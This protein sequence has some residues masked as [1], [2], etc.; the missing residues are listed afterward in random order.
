MKYFHFDNRSKANKRIPSFV[1]KSSPFIWKIKGLT[2][3]GSRHSSKLQPMFKPRF[4]LFKFSF[5]ASSIGQYVWVLKFKMLFMCQF[6]LVVSYKEFL[7]SSNHLCHLDT[8][9]LSE[10]GESKFQEFTAQYYIS[11]ENLR[12]QTIIKSLRHRHKQQI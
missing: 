8:Q 5:S 6:I 7:A 9:L 3:A 10:E 11:L 12:F 2:K 1:I 4:D